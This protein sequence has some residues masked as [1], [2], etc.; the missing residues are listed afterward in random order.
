MPQKIRIT[1]N[2][3]TKELS[4]NVAGGKCE[5]KTLVTYYRKDGKLIFVFSCEEV[6]PIVYGERD[7]DKLYKGD[8]V[9]VMI[10]LGSLERYLEIEVN[11]ANLKYAAIVGNPAPDGSGIQLEI[12]KE[13]PVETEITLTDD[14]YVAKILVPEA[15]LKELGWNKDDAYINFYRQDFSEVGELRLY[16]LSPTRTASFHKPSVFAQMETY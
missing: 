2:L 6:S 15:W 3:K 5:Q 7:N 14:G 16:A 9:E 12:L 1:D 10:T 8:I 11:P 4:E 13:H